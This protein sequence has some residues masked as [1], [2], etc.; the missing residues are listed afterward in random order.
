VVSQ[1]CDVVELDVLTTR[2][3]SLFDLDNVFP[4]EKSDLGSA[5][6]TLTQTSDIL[7]NALGR[8]QELRGERIG[9]N[10]KQLSAILGSADGSKPLSVHKD[11]AV[12]MRNGKA[13][14]HW[15]VVAIDNDEHADGGI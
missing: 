5:L 6:G 2:I 1:E 7:L 10:F 3:C 13:T 9:P 15:R 12:F 14:S 11:V 8:H 4:I